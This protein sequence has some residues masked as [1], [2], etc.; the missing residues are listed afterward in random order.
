MDLLLKSA[1]GFPA[2]AL[3][4]VVSLIL[5]AIFIG[6][7]TRVTPYPDI[8]L[9]RRGNLAAAIS[10]SGAI[11]GY[12]IPLGYSSAQSA[13]LAEMALWGAIAMITQILVYT[14][15]RMLLIPD[16]ANDIQ[17]GHVAQGTLL[18]ALSLASGILT[19]GCM[20]Y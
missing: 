17:E 20:T 9:I 14:A 12:A 8:D 10:L 4:L 1:S 15:V 5:L 19:A 7:Y 11:L 6:I 3:H 16:I 18:G 13:N 2:F